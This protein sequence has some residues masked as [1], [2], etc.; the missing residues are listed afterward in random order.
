L[1]TLFIV[2]FVRCRNVCC[3]IL[4]LLITLFVVAFFRYRNVC[5]TICFRCRIL[6]LLITMFVVA[7]LCCR[8]VRC[9][10]CVRCR[11]LILLITL[12]IV[13]FFLYRNVRCAICVRC[14]IL[15]LLIT[16]FVVAFVRCT[17]CVC[18]RILILLI[19]LFVVGTF[20]VAYPTVLPDG[21]ISL[22]STEGTEPRIENG[23]YTKCEEWLIEL[24]AKFIFPRHHDILGWVHTCNVTTYRNTVSWQCGRDSW[25]RNISKVGYAVTLRA[26]SVRCRYLAVAS[27]GWYGYGRSRCGR[28][29][30]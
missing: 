13:G 16:L 24:T 12:F 5:C 19:T 7:F 20:V 23:N 6:I 17:I 30:W 14:R 10:I 11:I 15:L 8:N 29:T 4:S 2:T 21:F 26:C 9:S 3:R 28:A 27:K 22:L 25:P 1:I 18:C